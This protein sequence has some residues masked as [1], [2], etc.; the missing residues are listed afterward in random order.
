MSNMLKLLIW[1]LSLLPYLTVIIKFTLIY[2]DSLFLGNLSHTY[3]VQVTNFSIP[4]LS[5]YVNVIHDVRSMILN[6]M[7]YNVT[8]N[9]LPLYEFLS[10]SNVSTLFRYHERLRLILWFW[11]PDI[12]IVWWFSTL[13]YLLQMYVWDHKFRMIV[14]Y[15][16]ILIT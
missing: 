16:E 11:T 15:T 3:E 6:I 10:L 1:H 7:H 9:H 5:L 13:H 8:N 12:I 2:F 14:V 4:Q